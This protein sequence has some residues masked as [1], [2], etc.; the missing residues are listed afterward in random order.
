MQLN[1]KRHELKY[2]VTYQEA[3]LLQSR[4]SKVMEVDPYSE[5][6]GYRVS[7]L[8]FDSCL[9]TSFY[10]KVEGFENRTKYRIRQY[11]VQSNHVKFEIKAKRNDIIEKRTASIKR[12]DLTSLMQGE[13]DCLLAYNNDVL[14]TIYRRFKRDYF[15]PVVIVQYYRQ[16]Y[17]M[18]FNHIRV[19]FDSHL[20]KGSDV[21]DFDHREPFMT[22]VLE[23][24]HV[25]LEI[26]YNHFLPK[27]LAELFEIARYTR[28][29]SSKYCL[30]RMA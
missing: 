3:L 19:T 23:K 30:S 22:P 20:K 11:D 12:K 5:N 21:L 29:A 4:I 17:L 13:Y 18:D 15:R 14:S 24:N 10:E 26:K 8:Y 27:W 28:C 2:H 16:A 25:V 9:N 1:V 6:G 7:S